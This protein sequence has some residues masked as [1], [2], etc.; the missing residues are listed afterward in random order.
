MPRATDAGRPAVLGTAGLLGLIRGGGV[1]LPLLQCR[2]VRLCGWVSVAKVLGLASHP[3]IR[4]IGWQQVQVWH[5]G[6]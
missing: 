3:F 6:V 1:P 4:P 5:V 2:G